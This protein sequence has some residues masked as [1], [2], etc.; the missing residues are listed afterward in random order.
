MTLGGVVLAAAAAMLGAAE[1]PSPSDVSRPFA[2]P[3]SHDGL[4]RMRSVLLA[5]DA[6]L[7]AFESNTSSTRVG[8]RNT[9]AGGTMMSFSS[10]CLFQNSASCGRQYQSV[11]G[12]SGAAWSNDSH[13]LSFVGRDATGNVE[14]AFSVEEDAL[15]SPN[16]T[17][18]DYARLDTQGF[19][20]SQFGPI[21]GATRRATA[22]L[23]IRSINL[24]RALSPVA[25]SFIGERIL[26]V[27]AESPLDLRLSI[28]D[29]ENLRRSGED[30]VPHL[31]RTDAESPRIVA[32]ADGRLFVA[33]LGIYVPLDALSDNSALEYGAP[34]LDS[35]RGVAEGFFSKRDIEWQETENRERHSAVRDRAAMLEDAYI[36]S[37][38]M[39]SLSDALLVSMRHMN[40]DVTYILSVDGQVRERRIACSDAESSLDYT[41][42]WINWG[43][44]ERPLPVTAYRNEVSNGSVILLPGGPGHN[45]YSDLTSHALG[46]YISAGYDVFVVNYSSSFGSGVDHSRR[47]MTDGLN[48]VVYDADRI[49]QHVR[50]MQ[51]EDVILH[52]ESFGAS[53]M[54][55]LDS[56]LFDG[57]I[58]VAPWFFHRDPSD[59]LTSPPSG[60][61]LSYQRAIE[62]SYFGDPDS[63]VRSELEEYWAEAATLWSPD[64]P[65][66]LIFGGADHISS[67]RDVPAANGSTTK[68][69]V[70]ESMV[71]QGVLRHPQSM[72]AI[73][74]FLSSPQR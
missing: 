38:S 7:I 69:V 64:T 17:R 30:V 41:L 16:E 10:E 28:F 61:Q 27:I 52:A 9:I 67:E 14:W 24:D 53:I 66:L 22:Y 40:G 62:N 36:E 6:Q 15:V 73:R 49:E 20:I 60:D 56:A 65:T 47:L 48:A 37:A 2:I 1:E 5:P 8:A 13:T 45:S 3:A 63:S 42:D 43:S 39:S 46:E 18:F 19:P 59:W 23:A 31:R 51:H 29:S 68:V 58:A 26:G 11:G 33:D 21:G 50:Q 12:I 44:A 55:S 25:A 35:Y 57:I 70:L 74:D 54:T 71:H 34:L 72:R 4:C 32:D